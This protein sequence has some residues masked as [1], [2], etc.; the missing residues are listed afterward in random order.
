MVAGFKDKENGIDVI[1]SS[2]A[3]L[4][5]R[6]AAAAIHSNRGKVSD[7]KLGGLVIQVV[8]HL[9]GVHSPS[10][11]QVGASTITAPG[12]NP[13]ECPFLQAK[14]KE[15][16]PPKS[17]WTELQKR[18]DG[19]FGKKGKGNLSAG[20]R[21]FLLHKWQALKY[22][23]KM[24]DINH[25]TDSNCV[26][27]CWNALKAKIPK[28]SAMD[29]SKSPSFSQRVDM[30]MAE[31]NSPHESDEKLVLHAEIIARITG[32][33]G[34]HARRML[35]RKSVHDHRS[36]VSRKTPEARLR[37]R[38]KQYT[39]SNTLAPPPPPPPPTPA[40]APTPPPTSPPTPPSAALPTQQR[41]LRSHKRPAAKKPSP[42][43]PL[44]RSAVRQRSAG[45]ERA[46]QASANR[47]ARAPGAKGT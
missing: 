45:V 33:V 14:G 21:D 2:G 23:E 41:P 30:V 17:Y 19:C 24:R 10:T 44:Q 4:I 29:T 31:L 9:H 38:E 16:E 1:T 7:D 46:T 43:R 28:R 34:F 36:A 15:K 5:K 27:A 26:E 3:K 18:R 22:L 47:R 35:R 12:C 25:Q 11:I 20:V 32:S 40:P 6:Q 39:N 8:Q 37:R 13:A 42:N